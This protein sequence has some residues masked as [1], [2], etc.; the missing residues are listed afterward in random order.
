[1]FKG[2]TGPYIH[3]KLFLL[4]TM[5]FI[6]GIIR[7][8]LAVIVYTVAGLCMYEEQHMRS[9]LQNP[10]GALNILQRGN[11]FVRYETVTAV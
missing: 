8:P 5:E 10:E 2:L 9:F 1:M 7:S 11:L 6:D 3:H 4:N